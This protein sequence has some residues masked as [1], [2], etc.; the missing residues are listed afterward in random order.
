MWLRTM[1]SSQFRVWP[2]LVAWG[3]SRGLV[4]SDALGDQEYLHPYDQP[5]RCLAVN[6]DPHGSI[7][8]VI[9]VHRELHLPWPIRL[10]SPQV[11]VSNLDHLVSVSYL[12]DHKLPKRF[13]CLGTLPSIECGWC[14]AEEDTR[15]TISTPQCD[16]FAHKQSLWRAIQRTGLLWVLIA[17]TRL[18][19]DLVRHG[20][21]C[22]ARWVHCSEGSG[23]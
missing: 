8:M 11:F 16:R 6:H 10:S 12:A 21:G 17:Q 23:T 18:P 4:L 22:L 2:T 5:D 7:L 19:R 9:S 14:L 13:I 1:H 20:V 3:K 15:H